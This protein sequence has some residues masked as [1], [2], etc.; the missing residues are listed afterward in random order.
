MTEPRPPD[1]RA[2]NRANWDERVAVHLGPRGY[3]IAALAAGTARLNAIEE[4]ELGPVAGLRILHLQCHF[5]RDSLILAQR[6]ARWSGWISLRRP[7]TPRG[8]WRRAW[9]WRTGCASWQADLYDAPTAVGEPAAFDAVYVTWGAL[10]W[11][12][13]I[14][15]WARMVAISSSRAAGSI[16]PRGI[17]LPWCWT[18][19]R[20]SRTARRACSRRIST[21]IR[22][23]WRNR[24]T[25]WIPQARLHERRHLPMDPSARQRGH[26]R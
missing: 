17:R 7:S 12:P 24:A 10:C 23:A 3:D 16:W 13:D 25:T 18:M 11:L 21:P 20:R 5:G 6:G 4:A 9:A 15:G 14:A 2:L 19:P 26:R 8:R 22:C 1:W